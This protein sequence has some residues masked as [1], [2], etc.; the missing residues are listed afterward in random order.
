[1]IEYT[2]K[3]L[4]KQ[5]RIKSDVIYM[6]EKIAFGSECEL[7]DIAA[8]EIEV[9]YE[10]LKMVVDKVEDDGVM[11]AAD[12]AFSYAASLFIEVKE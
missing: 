8:K 9:L 7:M 5:L 6:G 4:P 2:L 3:D 12:D 1:M 11:Y 10:A